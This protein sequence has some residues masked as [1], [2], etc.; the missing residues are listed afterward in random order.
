MNEHEHEQIMSE[1]NYYQELLEQVEQSMTNLA[2]TKQA[3]EDFDREQSKDVLAPIA[4]GVFVE[5]QIKS[6]DLFVNVGADVVSKK[7][8]KEAIEIINE[9]EKEIVLD[10]EKLIKKI[11][12]YYVL[13]QNKGE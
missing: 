7:T 10:K 5:A 6:K 2:N 4:N 11:N 3:L 13:L 9:Q 1:L 8:V 12:E